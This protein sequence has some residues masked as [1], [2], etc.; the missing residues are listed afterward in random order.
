MTNSGDED[1]DT[2]NGCGDPEAEMRRIFVELT[3]WVQNST[4]KIKTGLQDVE[5][6]VRSMSKVTWVCWLVFET[7]CAGWFLLSEG[8]GCF[9]YIF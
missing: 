8:A 6:R 5:I 9:S 2:S 7:A 1:A 3:S 4:R